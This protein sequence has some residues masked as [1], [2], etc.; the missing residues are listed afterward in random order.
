[1]R[2]FGIKKIK[3]IGECGENLGV[4]QDNDMKE[5]KKKVNG[6]FQKYR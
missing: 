6:F 2:L 5:L 1:M 4:V 3:F